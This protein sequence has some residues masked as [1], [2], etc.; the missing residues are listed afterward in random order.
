MLVKYL[1]CSNS[2]ILTF[3]FNVRLHY[4]D[5]NQQYYVHFPH[6]C[7]YCRTKPLKILLHV[8]SSI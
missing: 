7:Y 6:L 8:P 1:D 3:L 4:V 2:K 5:I